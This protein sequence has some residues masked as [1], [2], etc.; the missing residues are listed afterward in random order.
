MRGPLSPVSASQIAERRGKTRASVAR[1]HPPMHD[2]HAI[3]VPAHYTPGPN[4]NVAPLPGSNAYALRIRPNGEVLVGDTSLVVRLDAA[5][6]Q[7]QTYTLPGAT[8]IF[9]ANL[10]PDGTSF[11]TADYFGGT[12]YKVDIASG[13]VLKSWSAQGFQDLL[14]R[15]GSR[16]KARSSSRCRRRP[17]RRPLRRLRPRIAAA[18]QPAVRPCGRPTTS[19]FRRP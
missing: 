4:F 16:S 19:S 9:A 3:E 18:P 6:N 15:A 17:P 10:D 7:I 1:N 14:S 13:T 11:W 8:L 5:G 12:V 2:D